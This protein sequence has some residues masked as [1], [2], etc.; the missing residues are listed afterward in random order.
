MGRKVRAVDVRPQGIVIQRQPTALE[1]LTAYGASIDVQVRV[2]NASSVGWM[3]VIAKN[4]AAVAITH[5]VGV[6]GCAH[7]PVTLAL[8]PEHPVLMPHREI[9]PGFAPKRDPFFAECD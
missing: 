4:P 1:A 3:P 9:Q 5:L 6:L 7:F 8:T 2:G